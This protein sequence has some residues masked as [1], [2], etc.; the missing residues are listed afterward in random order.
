MPRGVK[1]FDTDF[2]RIGILTCFDINFPELW[3]EADLLDVDVVFWPSA[4]GGGRLLSA[5]AALY[6]YYVVPVGNGDFIDMTGETIANVERPR[7]KQFTA[8][9]D[10]DRTLVYTNFNR[11]KVE[12][13]LKDCHK[14]VELEHFFATESCFCFGRSRREHVCASCAKNWVSRPYGSTGT[15]AANRSTRLASVGNRSTD[16]CMADTALGNGHTPKTVP[17]PG[18]LREGS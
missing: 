4:Y 5:Y 2:G 15:A 7:P 13:L 11:K 10:L 8:T 6:N 9:L 14:D 3:H 17:V 12:K 16:V 18:Q 1:A